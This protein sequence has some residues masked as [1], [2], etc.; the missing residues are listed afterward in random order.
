MKGVARLS[1]FCR[2]GSKMVCGIVSFLEG[3]QD[4]R[5]VWFP[6][7]GGCISTEGIGYIR[8]LSITEA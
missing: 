2:G 6:E 5:V 4:S 1:V 3:T 7:I 8:D